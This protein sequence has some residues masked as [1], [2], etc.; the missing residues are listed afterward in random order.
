[1]KTEIINQL[2]KA[3]EKNDLEK[4]ETKLFFLMLSYNTDIRE[5]EPYDHNLKHI[6]FKTNCIHNPIGM[7]YTLEDYKKQNR[8]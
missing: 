4:C 8:F 5:N 3:Y 6:L 2:I 7:K 1:M